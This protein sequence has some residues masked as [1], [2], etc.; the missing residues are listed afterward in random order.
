MFTVGKLEDTKSKDSSPRK[1]S[2]LTSWFVTSRKKGID[3]VFALGIAVFF[4][5]AHILMVLSFDVLMP[6]VFLVDHLL[7]SRWYTCHL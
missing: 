1:E 2:L 6:A 5:T 4:Y 3:V 7:G